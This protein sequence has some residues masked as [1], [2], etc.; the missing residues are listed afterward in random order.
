MT[1][2]QKTFIQASFDE[3]LIKARQDNRPILLSYVRKLREADPLSFYHA[4]SNLYQGERFFFKDPNSSLFLVG[5]GNAFS[6]RC[7]Q[8]VDRFSHIEKQWEGITKEA[9]TY[10]P[11]EIRGTGP[12]IFGGFTFDPQ[13]DQEPE[14]SQFSQAI[15]QLPTYLLS[16]NHGEAYLT[17]NMIITGHEHESVLLRHQQQVDA[18]LNNSSSEV[19][20]PK[21]DQ[22]EEIRPEE[23]KKSIQNVTDRM[24]MED[25]EKVVLARKMKM[26]FSDKISS[27]YCI[28]HLYKEQKESFVFSLEVMNSCF[29]GASP[30][31]LLKK[32]NSMIYSTCLAGS[33]GRGQTDQ[34]DKVLGNELLHDEKNL[35]E[36]QL[37]VEMIQQSMER[38]CEQVQVPSP[39]TLLKM[40][41]IQHL[42]TP[43]M[44]KDKQGQSLFQLLKS[45]H[46][47]PALGGVPREAAMEV[48]RT[49]E[50]M[51][52]GFYAAPIGWVDAEGNGEFSVAI[53][54]GLLYKN[55]SYLYSGCGVVADSTPDSEYEETAI[56][57]RPML[58]AVGGVIHES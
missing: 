2:V 23:W 12:L 40:R 3:A 49:V 29:I 52:R 34:E 14:W 15:F 25:L 39:P 35:H 6:I 8:G 53:R 11:Y 28:E 4:G 50:E 26:T 41:D 44:G 22:L 19:S 56:K 20:V 54:S 5:L 13:R 17:T 10:N 37:V 45:F 55:E 9:L 31:R 27:D 48:I 43:V 47:T 58:R 7:G 51:D 33:I 1:T 24:K 38:Y 57:F 21:I 18:L 16:V 46:P 36:H 42:Y 32:K 30:E